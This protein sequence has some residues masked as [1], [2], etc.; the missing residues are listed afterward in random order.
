MYLDE[1]SQYQLYVLKEKGEDGWFQG[2][3]TLLTFELTLNP[4]LMQ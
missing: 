4:N 1:P 3:L 2:R